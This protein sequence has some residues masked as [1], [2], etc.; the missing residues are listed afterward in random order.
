M[1]PK[2]KLKEPKQVSSGV[3]RRKL[4]DRIAT[5]I[6]TIGGIAIILC[7]IAI[8]VFIGIET[9]PLWQGVKSELV[10]SFILKE[11]PDLASYS[12]DSPD[13]SQFPFVAAGTEQYKEI[14]FIVTND[15]MVNFLS[16]KDGS[17]I[18]KQQLPGLEGTKIV[19]SYV[20]ENNKLYSFGTENG[21]ILPV[22]FDF[23]MSFDGDKRS[24]A[25]AVNEEEPLNFGTSPL[26]IIA[27][28]ENEDGESAGAAYTTGGELL[29]TASVE[30]AS[31]L[32]G[33]EKKQIT[34]NLTGSLEGSDVTA[35]ELDRFTW[36]L[37]AG[38]SGGKLYHW[39]VRN[40]ENPVLLEV[41]N[42]APNSNTPITALAYLLGDRSLIVGDG[43]GDVSVWFEVSEPDS[44]KGKVLKRIHD[45]PPMELP[46]VD[47]LPSARDRGF[48]AS[49][50][51]GNLNLY[52]ATSE[53]KLAS[54]K[55]DGPRVENLVYSP[56]AD[57]I[58]AID[59]KSKLYDWDID[60]SHPE[61]SFKTLFG[62]VWYEGY[63]KPEYVWQ[64]TGGTDDFEPKFSLTPLAFGTLKGAIYAL[65]FAIPLSIFA[66]LCVSQ[67]MHPALRNTIKPII[68]VM[69]ALP[70]VVL[71][72]FAGL[73]LA[74]VIEKI[75]PAI[76]TMP[77]VLTI[78]TL[79]AVFAWQALPRRI[80]GKFKEGSELFLLV[81]VILL[82]VIVTLWINSP[83]EHL[84]FGGDYKSW[85]YNVLGLQYDQ[86]NSLIVG[87]AMGFAVIPIIFT[88]SED[89]LTSVPKHLA[90]GSLALGANKWQTAIRVILPTASPGIFS[91]V[92]IGLGRAIGETMIVLMATGNTPIMDWS[93]FNG[94]RALSANIAVEIPEAPHGG[95]L[96]RILFLAAL[97]LFFF[98]FIINTAAELVRQNLRKKY[99]QI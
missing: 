79:I 55:T 56:K 11:S 44:P 38:T 14:G 27:Y 77:I 19:S 69:A 52:H 6:V 12:L 64:S 68:E 34:H 87:F 50:N 23:K 8:L 60:N 3:K 4:A 85:F 76:F 35:L 84:V 63:S 47:I 45:L 49:D 94:F 16:L 21:N 46:V 70:S 92:M 51:G 97:L 31:L 62:K 59:R 39:D 53:Q 13:Q 57:G 1:S 88:I 43:A 15:G 81:P 74:P 82:G 96:Y 17:T 80:K 41:L 22:R 37:Y 20:S 24:I 75:I 29:L 67:F 48:I 2:T 32:G 9:V 28:E 86:R 26:A 89:A 99:G 61:T 30:S 5:V 72:F 33:G 54:F 18:K 42:A 40:K 73:W 65:L 36:N 91:A 83:V 93:I 10:S 98:T 7:I 95:T 71:G 78:F 66:A 90:A 58:M 25:P